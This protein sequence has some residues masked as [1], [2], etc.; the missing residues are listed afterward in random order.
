MRLQLASGIRRVLGRSLAALVLAAAPALASAQEAAPVKVTLSLDGGKKVYRNGE[1][2]RLVM[3]FTSEHGGYQLNTTT[4]K[5]PSAV[6]AVSLA[7]AADV[8]AWAEHYTGGGGYHPDYSTISQLSPKPTAVGLTL[9][10]WYRFDR[11]G[12]YTAKVTTSRVTGPG[13]RL[14]AGQPLPLTTN[15]VSFEIVEVSEEAEAAEVRRISALL[16]AAKNWQEEAQLADELA[17]L[18]GEPSAREKVRR[19]LAGGRSGNYTQNIHLGLVMARDRALVVRLLE[20]AI[21]DPEVN[22]SHGL[23]HTAVGLRLMLE[24]I[25]RP[26]MGHVLVLPGREHPRSAELLR[27]Y[28]AE[29]MAT[30]PKRKGKSRTA[31]AMAALT[32]LPRGSDGAVDVPPAVRAVLVGEFDS[33]HPFDQEYL[34][35]VYWEQ[36]SDPSMLP[37]VERMLANN[38]DPRSYQVRTAAL[39]RLTE[40]SAERARPHILAELRNPSS[41]VDY[42]VLSALPDETLP[43][44]DD[45]LL[46]QIKA[47]AP[48]RQNFDS[49]LLRHKAMLVARYASPD[50]YDGLLE[51]Y[52][53]WGDKWQPDPRGAILGYLARHNPSQALPLVEQALVQLHSGQDLSFLLEL[54]RPGYPGAVRELLR[55]RLEGDDPQAA[56]TA[57]YVISQHGAKEDEELIEARLG[58]WRKEWGGRAAELDAGDAAVVQRMV[59]INLVESLLRSKVWKLPEEKA[60][61]IVRGCVSEDCRRRYGAK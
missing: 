1:P 2:V 25:P 20:A 10:D 29:L 40:L 21:R 14:G 50:I 26:K 31:A 38:R 13:A 30:L 46:E 7:P 37:A 11:P 44:V 45:A 60:A 33:F 35:R 34:L 47:L 16:D 59:E 61:R 9:N 22:P 17:Y 6:D 41:V 39:R 8:Y 53:A 32:T 54:T 43:E 27:E 28:A 52:R 42:E 55:R 5:P 48:Q 51:T 15:E 3:S 23:L 24:G 36:L 56:G 19:Y 18:T 57:A 49:T 4:T 12:K 58:R